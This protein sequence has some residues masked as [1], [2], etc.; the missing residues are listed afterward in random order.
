MPNGL[1][2]SGVCVASFAALR[3]EKNE[4]LLLHRTDMDRWCLPGGLLEVGESVVDC[5]RRECLEEL[6]VQVDP[7]SLLGAYSNPERHM[8]SFKNG[9]RVHYIVFVFHSII[10]SGVVKPDK[11]EARGMGYFSSHD[12]PPLVNSHRIWIEDSF[13]LPDQ[14][15]IR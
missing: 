1:E 6:N 15:Y 13:T 8:F 3:N 10:V 11:S 5:L 14:P 7:I 9:R 12:L 2:L 4:V